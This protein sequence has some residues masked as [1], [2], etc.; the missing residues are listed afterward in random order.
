LVYRGKTYA[1][2]EAYERGLVDEIADPAML[3]SRA[4]EVASQLG[5]EPSARFRITKQQLRQPT[6]DR[7]ERYAEQTQDDVI[8][9]WKDPES[10][11]SIRRYLTGLR[12]DESRRADA[13]QSA[14]NEAEH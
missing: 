3:V 14:A 2:A 13:E 1:V 8:A 12:R 10:L 6:I 9:A 4:I 11:E 5:S 7:M